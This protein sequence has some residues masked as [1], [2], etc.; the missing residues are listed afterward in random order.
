M[1]N[2][3]LSKFK[4]EHSECDFKREV[5]HKKIKNWLKSVCAFANGIGGA[6]VFGI[7]DE[8]RQYFPIKNMQGEIEFITQC[9]KDRI[10]PIPEFILEP[11]AMDGNDILVLKIAGGLHTPYYLNEGSSKVT[12]IRAGSSSV[13]ADTPILHELILKGTNRTWDTLKSEYMARDYSF[14]YLASYYLDR[15]GKHLTS[16]DYRSFGFITKDGFLT[17]AGDSLYRYLSAF[18]V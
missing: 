7:D 13:L 15:T 17:N 6:L 8:N 5:E 18:A 1:K 16:A 11:D 2:L 4:L 10:S 12:F 9:I 14:T 3:T